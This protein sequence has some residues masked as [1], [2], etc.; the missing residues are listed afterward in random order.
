M[1][2]APRTDHSHAG[3][4]RRVREEGATPL[5][6]L[7]AGVHLHTISCPNEAAFVRVKETLGSLGLLLNEE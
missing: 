2:E 5:S 3:M 4:L 6:L 7:T 1:A